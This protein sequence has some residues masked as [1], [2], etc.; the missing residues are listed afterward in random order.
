MAAS[1]SVA[2]KPSLLTRIAYGIGGA[3]SGVKNNGFEYFLLLYYSQVLG[4][5]ASLVAGA[6]FLALVVDAVSDPVVGYWSDNVRTRFGRR[7]PFMYAAMLPLG[8]AY[9]LAWNPPAGLD[10]HGLFLWL[11][12]ITITVRLCFTFYE[13]PSLA[14]A[15]ELTQDYDAR[16]SLMSFRYFFAWVGGLA[17]QVALLTMLLRP[18]ETVKMGFFNLDGWHTY[19]LW[20]ALTIV[21]AI[22]IC[23]AGTHKY[24]PYLKAAPAARQL[25]VGKVFGEIFETVSNPSFRALF[26]ATLFGLFAS[27][28]SAALN[29]YINGFFW[30]FDTDQI[31]GLTAG[32]FVSAAIALVVAPIIGKTLGKKRGSIIIGL[33]AFTIAPAPV[34]ARLLGFMPPNGSDTLYYL[35]LFITVF[36]LALIIAT[37]MLMA[38]MV[39]DIVEE[40]ELSTGR[41]SE[42]IFFAGISFIRKLSQGAGILTAA[43]VLSMADLRP[44]MQPGE[45]AET[46]LNKL[47]W[48]YAASLLVIWMLMILCISFYRISRESH[49]A[50]LA[51]LAARD[52]TDP[53][54]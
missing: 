35:V 22:A 33:L 27:G 11:V 40:S 51:A 47:G 21:G 25:S 28:I 29:Q 43:V 5:S 15:A 1:L 42:G 12:V 16:T 26:L 23:A 31:A 44:G 17:I 10:R 45:V 2:R 54:P 38:A 3:A 9:F 30:E 4:I 8:V 48:G 14:L 37:Q 52:D 32:V 18:T 13:V 50:N 6:L 53:T 41:R 7:H 39:A 19:G 34:L 46:S 36:D 20:A 49:E 24:I